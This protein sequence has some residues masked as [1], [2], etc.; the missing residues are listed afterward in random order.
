MKLLA[1]DTSSNACSVALLCGGI[2]TEKHLV[3]PRMHTRILIPAINE[4]IGSAGI[5]IDDLDAI[6]LGNGPGS[7]IGMRIGASVAQGMAHGAGKS[8]VA[9]S[10]MAAVAAE[11]MDS[12]GADAVVVTQDAR[13]SEVYT[14][15]YVRSDAG[16]PVPEI[17]EAIFAAGTLAC[18]APE[19]D[20]VAAGAGWQRHPDMLAANAGRVVR[21]SA[22]ELPRARYL[23]GLAV[24]K[25][26]A[27]G[28]IPPEQ[29]QP[30][31]LRL[32]VA[33]PPG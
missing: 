31:Y 26:E 6:A 29:V 21:M 20:Y 2:I 28:A 19:T 3:E 9:I 14:G 10:S 25:L 5:V 11:V 33:T 30:A 4:L 17:D 18:L 1:L 13:M 7:F 24:D 16:L 27:G 23:L 8:I 32:Q 22:I 12:E 15:V